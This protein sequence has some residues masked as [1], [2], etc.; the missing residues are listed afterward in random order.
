MR[1]SVL[2][3]VLIAAVVLSGSV[4]TE[5]SAINRGPR[6]V[7]DPE[8]AKAKFGGASPELRSLPVQHFVPKPGGWQEPRSTKP[9]KPPLPWAEGFNHVRS[10]GDAAIRDFFPTPSAPTPAVTATFEGIGNQEQAPVIG[11]LPLPPDTNG[12]IGPSHYVQT[13]NLTMKVFDR[14]GNTLVGPIKTSA[15]FTGMGGGCETEN[16]GDPIVLYDE[17]A[18]RW[19]ISQFSVSAQPFLQCIA[20]SK[21]GDPTGSYWRYAFEMPNDFFNDYPHFGV[22]SDGYYMMDHQFNASLTAYTGAGVFAF[23]RAK[24]LVGDPTASYIYFNMGTN[25]GGHLPADVDGLRPP[26]A[27]TPNYFIFFDADEF[28]GTDSVQIYGFDADWSNP[29]NSTFS[30]IISLPVAAYDPRSPSGRGDVPQSGTA[31]RLDAIADRFMNRLAY[32][33]FGA[34]ESLAVAQTVNVG[35]DISAPNFRAA[36]RYYEFRRALPSGAWVV[37]RQGTTP[38]DGTH[39]WMGSAAQDHAGN[40]AIGYSAS[41]GSIFPSIRFAGHAAGDPALAT[42]QTM[43]A[44]TGSQTSTS[45]R[46]GDYS[47]MSVDPVDGCTFWYTTEYYAAPSSS[48]NWRTRVGNFRYPTC[49]NVAR[50]TVSG[51]V[52][53][54]STN[55]VIAD[56]LV[57]TSGFLRNTDAAGAYSMTVVPGTYDIVA[58]AAGYGSATA[59]SVVVADSGAIIQNFLLVPQPLLTTGAASAN[60]APG[61]GNGRIEG[62]ECATVSITLHNSGG[63]PATGV[64]AL[65]SS[66]TPGVTVTT[67][68]SAYPDIAIGGNGVNTTPFAI[69]TDGTYSCGPLNLSLEVTSAAGVSTY[70]VTIASGAL[71][72][73]PMAFASADVPK[74]LPDNATTNSVVTVSGITTAPVKATVS[75]HMTHTFVSD[76]AVKLTSPGGQTITL[77]ANRGGSGDNMG[78]SCAARLTFDD[79]A[80][81]AIGSGTAPFAGTF[82]PEQP[83][84]NVITG[85][86]NGTWTLAMTDSFTQDQG[87]LQCW[88]LE[89][90]PVQCPSI[91]ATPVLSGPTSLCPGTTATFVAPAGAASYEWYKNGVLIDGETGSS[92]V[93]ASVTESDAG[94]YSVKSV[95]A[96]G[97][98]SAVSNTVSLQVPACTV[99]PNAIRLDTAVTGTGDGNGIIEPGEQVAVEPAWSNAGLSAIDL[100]ST[101]SS[102]TGPGDA[103]AYTLSDANAVY[104]SIAAGASGW[105][106]PNGFMAGIANVARPA[107]HWDA[108]FTETPSSTPFTPMAPKVWTLHVGDSFVDVPRSSVFYRFIESIFHDQVTAGVGGGLY[109]GAASATRAQMAAFIS[110]SLVAPLGDAAVPVAGT[111][112]AESYDCTPGGTSLFNDVLPTHLFCKH[113]HYLYANNITRGCAADTGYCQTDVTAR[114]TMAVFLSRAM[115]DPMGDENVPSAYTDPATGRGYDCANPASLGFTD[116]GA[117][118]VNCRH[119]Y[120]IWARG[121]VDGFVDGT[122]GPSLPVSREQMAKFLANAFAL[123]ANRP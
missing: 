33:N 82:R 31:V 22:W 69:A 114:R 113:I 102:F 110:R 78:S 30:E 98:A 14:A 43:F 121:V 90:T 88:T 25:F 71:P 5:V 67:A 83:L 7:K 81:T 17:Q 118:D 61:N 103:G 23:D 56:A 15:L 37:Q 91:L 19:L 119:I 4:T 41:S 64:S 8:V 26:P 111:A 54:A 21:T 39:R 40:L 87:T 53:D 12:D 109:D 80:A 62:D 44:G 3:R 35:T 99:S 85:A 74:F 29:A 75:L 38:N 107:H 45:N 9:K 32:R 10:S 52:R 48:S 13:V 89:I 101:A 55:A 24:M 1:I 57:T 49:V 27:G 95:N 100:S 11:I 108:S 93:I 60:D 16:D 76:M 84:S 112:G 50:G 42:E 105:A 63:A 72:G 34:Y 2:A 120:Y 65:L 46:W 86:V 66:T 77:F 18:D 92:L 106:S 68:A 123:R 94:D 117:A 96:C 59:S 6:E 104:G 97:I 28:G 20:I 115:V 116:V 79:A 70:P 58:S 51:T 47:A 122:Y 73:S 36:T